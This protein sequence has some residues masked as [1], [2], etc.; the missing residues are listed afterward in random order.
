MTS[1]HSVIMTTTDSEEEAARLAQNLVELK[2]AACV[3]VL[4]VTSHYSWQ[5]ALEKSAEIL[6]LVKTSTSR[7]EDVQAYLKEH[8][9][10]DTPEVVQI[11]ITD[12]SADYLSW[13]DE[14]T[15]R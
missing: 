1:A 3:Q 11:P 7:F 14:N 12:G 4:P 2:L 15:T 5:G 9:S 13:I 6:L 8:H 10:Y